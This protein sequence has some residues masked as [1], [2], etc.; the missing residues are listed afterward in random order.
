MLFYTLRNGIGTQICISATPVWKSSVEVRVV[1]I[2][3]N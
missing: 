3:Q 2:E 1:I